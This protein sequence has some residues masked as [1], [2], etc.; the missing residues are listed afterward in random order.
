[1]GR[2]ER[3]PWRGDGH[4]AVAEPSGL[5]GWH[6]ALGVG[7]GTGRSDWGVTVFGG[8]SGLWGVLN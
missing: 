2:T 1:M 3:P 4:V 7:R 6:Q 5:S 8:T